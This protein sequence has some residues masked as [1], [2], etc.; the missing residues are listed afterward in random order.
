MYLKQNLLEKVAKCL[1]RAIPSKDIQE[2]LIKYDVDLY[3]DFKKMY[4]RT[5][6]LPYNDL[7]SKSDL[8]MIEENFRTNEFLLEDLRIYFKNKNY[9]K[10]LGIF[11]K[12]PELLEDYES[13]I[14]YDYILYVTE[15]LLEKKCYQVYKAYAD[16]FGRKLPTKD[17]QFQ[18]CMELTQKKPRKSKIKFLTEKLEKG[19]LQLL[20]SAL[21]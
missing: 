1:D 18:L 14:Y 6:K 12:L 7:L 15:S 16:L 5:K 11:G 2:H 10:A 4:V 21:L 3:L 19:R 13:S 8:K 9:S 20:R 17:I